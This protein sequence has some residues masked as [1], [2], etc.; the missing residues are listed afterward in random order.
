MIQ[1][2]FFD[3]EMTILRRELKKSQEAIDKVRKG[4]YARINSLESKCEDLEFRLKVIES[5]IC[6]KGDNVLEDIVTPKYPKKRYGKTL[7]A[8]I[9]QM[10]FTFN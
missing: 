6:K 7:K 8:D 9:K 1:L 5:N 2:E 10:E 3:D 4:T